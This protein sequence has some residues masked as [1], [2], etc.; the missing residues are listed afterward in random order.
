MFKFLDERFGQRLL[1]QK[2]FPEKKKKE[3]INNDY[4][5]KPIDLSV[6]S[7]SKKVYQ[8]FIGISLFESG[9]FYIHYTT[10]HGNNLQEIF[11]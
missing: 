4:I 2:V 9:V 1:F 10:K 11:V 7:E 5:T 6:H 3:E 8:W